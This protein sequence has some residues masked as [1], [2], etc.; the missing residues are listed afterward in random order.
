MPHPRHSSNATV[1]TTWI[2]RACFVL[3]PAAWFASVDYLSYA[4]LFAPVALVVAAV[5][6]F[7]ASAI[8]IAR[9]ERLATGVLWA[10][11]LTIAIWW[12]LFAISVPLFGLA[13]LVVALPQRRWRMPILLV[14]SASVCFA[15]WLAP[16][17]NPILEDA[18]L[19]KLDMPKG[20]IPQAHATLLAT[21]VASFAVDR[22]PPRP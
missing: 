1:T 21:L 20:W 4:V 22:H 7:I 5:L 10:L 6:A 17:F 2:A 11:F 13:V 15:M 3:V 8:A 14:A 9:D 19:P 12:L 16:V 18:F